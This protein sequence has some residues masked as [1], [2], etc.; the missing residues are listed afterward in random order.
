[1][2]SHFLNI[3]CIWYGRRLEKQNIL[4]LH[5]NLD[6]HMGMTLSGINDSGIIANTITV[7]IKSNMTAIMARIVEISWNSLIAKI[8]NV[9]VQSS[10]IYPIRGIQPKSRFGVFEYA[11][12]RKVVL[13]FFLPPA[14]Y[15]KIWRIRPKKKRWMRL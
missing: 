6:Y 1:M 7:R 5:P 4:S 14:I 3:I 11:I 12:M 13:M 2:K 8:P 15:A 9:N 10:V